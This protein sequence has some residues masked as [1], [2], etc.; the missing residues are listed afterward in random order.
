MLD[1]QKCLIF[2]YSEVFVI[3]YHWNFWFLYYS[4]THHSFLLISSQ[5]NADIAKKTVILLFS[6]S[7]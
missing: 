2:R 7:V 1:T 6:L 5:D 4:Y 3:E